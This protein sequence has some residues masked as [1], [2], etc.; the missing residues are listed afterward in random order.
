MRV[1]LLVSA[2]GRIVAR[3][4]EY[5]G[6]RF[7]PFCDACGGAGSFYDSSSRAQVVPP[8]AVAATAGALRA[9]GFEVAVEAGVEELIRKKAEAVRRE[10]D[11]FRGA[12]DGVEADLKERGLSLFRFQLEGVAKLRTADRFLLADEMGLG[13]TVQALAALPTHRPVVVIAPAAVKGVWAA[14]C[15]KWRPDYRPT[16]LSGRGTFRWPRDGELLIVNYDILPPSPAELKEAAAGVRRGPSRK[17]SRMLF[18]LEES[19][20]REGTVIIADE[21][22]ALK[23]GK[24]LRTKRFAALAKTVAEKKGKLWL[25]TGTPILNRPPE[26]WTLLRVNGTAKVAFPGGWGEFIRL[27][28]AVPGAYGMR[29]SYEPLPEVVERIRR[30]SLKRRRTEVLPDL[31]RKLHR[32]IATPIDEET[33]KACDRVLVELRKKGID[34]EAAFEEAAATKAFGAAFEEMSRARAMLATAKIPALLSVV[35]EFEEQDEPLVVFSAHRPPVDLLEGRPGWATITGSTAPEERTRIVERFQTGE[36]RGLGVTIKAGG[37]GLTLTRAAHALFVD[38]EWT[39]AL[40]SQAEDRL[41]RIGQTRGVQ[42]T[43]LVA[44]HPL[45]ERVAELLAEKQKLIEASTE[46]AAVKEVSPAGTDRAAELERIAA[47]AAKLREEGERAGLRPRTKGPFPSSG[48]P[49]NRT[50][51]DPAAGPPA[52][53]AANP[54]P[55]GFR[56]PSTPLEEWAARGLLLLHGLNP[57]GAAIRNDVGF[58]RYDTRF[59]GSLAEQLR[60]RGK[61]SDRQWE[62]GIKMLRKY[63]GQVGAPPEE[64]KEVAP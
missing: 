13:K 55:G 14:E 11:E 10:D 54:R 64:G 34:L 30:V 40:N 57:D 27:F 56:A 61:L 3:P 46:A 45:D 25:L 12:I 2:D 16:V 22:H 47:D 29:W 8:E 19:P 44:D 50:P 36:L 33:R 9:A 60:L 35:E 7:R 18:R 43:R 52:G 31:P 28:R 63:R 1:D 4:G 39:P 59:G 6:D 37:V 15:R 26:L 58:N 23:S 21:A 32:D 62:V 5:L 20:V 38:L 42:V 51:G 41:C 48:P 49:A 53:S 17:E 24:T